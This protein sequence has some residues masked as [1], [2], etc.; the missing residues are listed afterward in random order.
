MNLIY[1]KNENYFKT[2]CLVKSSSIT[3]SCISSCF[4]TQFHSRCYLRYHFRFFLSFCVSYRLRL[5]VYF[6]PN[7]Y[8]NYYDFSS[9]S[10]S[11]EEHFFI[12]TL[13]LRA[14]VY[15]ALVRATVHKSSRVAAPAGFDHRESGSRAVGSRG[16]LKR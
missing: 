1:K 15:C 11:F 13:P 14:Q 2:C 10:F 3:A 4:P 12:I 5:S 6:H 16:Q 8:L 9:F 7:L